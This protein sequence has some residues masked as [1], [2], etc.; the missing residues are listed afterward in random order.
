[1]Q[2]TLSPEEAHEL[3]ALVASALSDIRSEIHYTDSPEFRERLVDRQR[4][5]QRLHERL[6]A[7]E[8]QP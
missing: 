7:D 4:V 1:M 2:L 8:A 6:G 5:L 3:R